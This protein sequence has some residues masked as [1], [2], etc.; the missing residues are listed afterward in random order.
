MRLRRT[1]KFY[2][3]SLIFYSTPSELA[4]SL[5]DFSIHMPSHRWRDS[6]AVVGRGNQCER[7]RLWRNLSAYGGWSLSAQSHIIIDLMPL[8]QLVRPD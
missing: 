8:L 3:L 7:V 6:Q 5:W 2:T 4:F 1:L